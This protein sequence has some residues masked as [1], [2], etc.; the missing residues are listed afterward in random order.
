MNVNRITCMHINND[1]KNNMHKSTFTYYLVKLDVNKN[2][3][4]TS[5]Y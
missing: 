3:K 4:E 5:Y 2:L 1:Q